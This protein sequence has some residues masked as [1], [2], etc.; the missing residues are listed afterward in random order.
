MTW[1]R[2]VADGQFGRA[3]DVV[4]VAVS[5]DHSMHGSAELVQNTGQI[6]GNPR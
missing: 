6:I 2:A 3:G 1:A 4:A 5:C